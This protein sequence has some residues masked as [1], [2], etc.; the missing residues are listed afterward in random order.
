MTI[1]TTTVY[2]CNGCGKQEDDAAKLLNWLAIHTLHQELVRYGVGTLPP[3][4]KHYCSVE[5]FVSSRKEG[6]DA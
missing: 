2:E 6:E 4:D 3:V 1:K 5:C